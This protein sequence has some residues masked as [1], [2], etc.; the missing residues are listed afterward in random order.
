MVDNQ[1]V[2]DLECSGLELT[3]KDCTVTRRSGVCNHG[4]MTTECEYNV[5]TLCMFYLH[6][7]CASA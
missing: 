1:S 7:L 6:V 4:F 3:I 2:Y 5:Y